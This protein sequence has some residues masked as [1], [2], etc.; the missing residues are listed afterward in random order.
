LIASAALSAP[1]V[2]L[3]WLDDLKPQTRSYG[4]SIA[5]TPSID[6]LSARVVRVLICDEVEKGSE[7]DVH[8]S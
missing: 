7:T 2:L 1:N 3:L 8:H 4:A 6:R 5:Q